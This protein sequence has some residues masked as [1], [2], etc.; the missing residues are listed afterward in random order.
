MSPRFRLDGKVA[1]VT[2]ASSG[3]GAHF[4]RLLAAEGA[5]VALVARRL[6]RIEAGVQTIVA[7]GGTA[8]AWQMDVTDARSVAEA[9]ASVAA[10]Y[11]RID[12]LINNAGIAA[13]R[14]FLEQ[15]EEGWR[16]IIDTNLSG[17]MRAGRE[18]AKCMAAQ[19][20]GGAIVNVAS[21][22]GLRTAAQ[23]APYAAAKAGVISLTQTM[24][25]ELARHAVRVNALAP[26]YVET[27][28][29]RDFLRGPAG[30]SL[31][32]RVPLRR[33]GEAS[34]LD[35]A[36]L[37]LASDAGRFVTGI[38]LPVDGGHLLSFL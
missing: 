3:L 28:L 4:A 17:M 30:Q 33:F 5:Q 14:P 19:G 9:V 16:T 10:T 13:T 25:L 6:D 21:I 22:L 23:L 2:G 27:D 35:G 7:D 31:V 1:L 29:N 18:V 20:Q 38:T 8:R 15:D 12:V 24:A 32:K 37:L 36:L 26:G 11:G 34:D